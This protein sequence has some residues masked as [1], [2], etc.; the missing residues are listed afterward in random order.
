MSW[1]FWVPI[2]VFALTLIAYVISS[3]ILI[4]HI[5]EFGYLGESGKL[6]KYIYLIWTTVIIITSILL[7][8]IGGL[9]AK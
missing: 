2:I 3:A 4:Y 1:F 7:L 6:I 8:I 9:N 5:N